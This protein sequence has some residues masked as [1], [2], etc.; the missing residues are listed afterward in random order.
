M[1]PLSLLHLQNRTYDPKIIAQAQ[2]IFE[3]ISKNILKDMNYVEYKE[4]IYTINYFILLLKGYI[5]LGDKIVW[6]DYVIQDSSLNN[7][8]N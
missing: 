3:S 7:L 6:N 1:N 5:V 4:P 2:E 8:H